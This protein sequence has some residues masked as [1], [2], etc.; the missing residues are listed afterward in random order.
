M[1]TCEYCGNEH[2][3]TYGSGRF[4]SP[5]CARKFS[6]TF[7][8][9]EGR[10]RQIKA[11]NDEENRQ[12]IA[13]TRKRKTENSSNRKSQF[14]D[15]LCPKFNHTLTLGKIGEL[16]V[17]IKFLQHGYDVYIPLVDTGGADLVVNNRNGEGFKTV[18]V[19]SSTDSRINNDG[20]CEATSFS[21]VRHIRYI[22]EGS[23]TQVKA[24]YDP[25]EIDYFALY[26]AYE[27]ELYL[28]K[29]TDST[30]KAF[31]IRNMSPYYTNQKSMNRAYNYQID[32]VLDEMNL[33]RGVS[34]EY[35]ENIIDGEFAELN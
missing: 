20:V 35:E 22:H 25:N 18:Q 10:Q 3:G 32:K 1:N 5:T 21:L 30:P 15:D 6:G 12:K 2:E 4:C 27:N 28:I 17:G 9:E 33:V 31:T 7:V 19:K 11:L 34:Y 8:S 14:R 13:E 23:Y 24:K 16:E 26:S 29:N